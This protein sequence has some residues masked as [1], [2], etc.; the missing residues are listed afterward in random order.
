MAYVQT[1]IPQEEQNQQAPVGQ[2]T[3]NPL[4]QMPPNATETGGS[5]GQGGESAPSANK[6]PGVGNSTQFGTNASRLSDYLS[7]NQDQVQGMGQNIAGTLNQNYNQIYGDVNK[8]GQD[9]ANTVMGSYAAPNPE[10]VGRAISNPTDFVKNS[11]DVTAFQ[12][13]LNDTYSGPTAFESTAPYAQVQGRVN[14]AVQGSGLLNTHA[15][16]SS[17]LQNN[18]EKNPTQGQNMLDTVLLESQPQA[19]KAVQDAAAPFAGL[20]NYLGDTTN[21]ANARVS[22]AQQAASKARED[23]RTAFSGATGDF[24]NSLNTR[25]NDVTNQAKGFNTNFNDIISRLSGDLPEGYDNGIKPLT[26]DEQNGLKMTNESLGKYANAN[27]VLDMYGQAPGPIASFTSQYGQS[28]GIP[29]SSFLEGGN[30]TGLPNSLQDTSTPEDYA[31]AQAFSQL[32]G[33][34]FSSPIS[35]AGNYQ[36]TGN[37]QTFNQTRA[38]DLFGQ[39]NQRDT[40]LANNFFKTNADVPQGDLNAAFNK[41]NNEMN[42]HPEN[43][44]PNSGAL[45]MFQALNRL[46]NGFNAPNPTFTP[47]APSGPPFLQPPIPTPPSPGGGRH[48]A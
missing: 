8:A 34:Q 37:Y 28:A 43:F 16:L 35:G 6:A 48:F 21:T 33:D 13:Q 18:V 3:A 47:P 40:A 29:L 2:T 31:T 9:F 30:T 42:T 38:N 23:T 46:A 27:Q 20:T 4:A 12:A 5:V 39:V 14:Q 24:T 7:A 19:I 36:P 22:P 45:Y 10:L 32:G 11:N 26:V 44:P 1:P 25:F 17:Y 41:L 15:G